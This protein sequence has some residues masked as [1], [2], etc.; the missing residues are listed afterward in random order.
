MSYFLL[1][2]FFSC[3]VKFL[4][5]M[6]KLFY[7]IIRSLFA[8]SPADYMLN[9]PTELEKQQLQQ[10]NFYRIFPQYRPQQKCLLD[11]LFS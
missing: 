3:I 6:I 11:E 2:L 8:E 5:E 4:W 1:L 7:H 9:H 10:E